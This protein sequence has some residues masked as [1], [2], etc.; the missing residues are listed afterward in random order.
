MPLIYSRPGSEPLFV[1]KKKERLCVR[2][3]RDLARIEFR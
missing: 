1:K 2:K 3:G